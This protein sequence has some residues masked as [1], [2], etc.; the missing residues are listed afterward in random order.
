MAFVLVAHEEAVD[1]AVDYGVDL[2]DLFEEVGGAGGEVRG[3]KMKN[4]DSRR[5]N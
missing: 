4:L 3:Q 1:V 5:T 2:L